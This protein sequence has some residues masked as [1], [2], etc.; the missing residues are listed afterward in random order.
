MDSSN[1]KCEEKPERG[2]ALGRIIVTYRVRSDAAAIEAR[3]QAIAVEQSVETPLAAISDET[4]L[5]DIV[6]EVQGVR[7]PEA[8]LFEV[9]IGL[10]V[11]TT[12]F[13]AGQLLS[14]LFGNASLQE[15]VTLHDAEIPRAMAA[16][17]GGPNA[18]IAGLRAKSGARGRA[19]TCTALKPQGLP[20]RALASLAGRLAAGGIDVIKDDH[21]LADQAYSPFADRVRAC[22]EA[23]RRA[24]SR[25]LYVPN[26]SGGLDGAAAQIALAMMEGVEAVMVAPMIIGVSN[27][28]RLVR[29]FPNMAF[30]AHPAMA[31]A[32]RI[33]PPLLLG[34]LFR[35]FGADVTIYPNYG[36]RFSYSPETCKAIADAA[37]RPWRGLQ[38]CMP[39]PAGGMTLDRVPE[40]LDFYGPDT[41]LLIGGSLLSAKD[42]LTEATAAFAARV[43]RTFED[44]TNG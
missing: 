21:G 26:I 4:V 6:G 2:D 28:H 33:A 23:V 16:A 39:C 8:G 29:E 31:G 35:L 17:F 10:A 37:R 19:L 5:R 44:K 9:R 22:A 18:G 41:M 20:P 43:S 25:T 1:S 38:P 7:E 14:M 12:G 27:F 34:K 3:A 15:D 11:E 42:R 24:G 30:F 13:E 40:I 36:G 32:S